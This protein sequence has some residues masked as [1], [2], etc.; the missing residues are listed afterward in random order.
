MLSIILL[1]PVSSDPPAGLRPSQVCGGTVTRRLRLGNGC[2]YRYTGELF[3]AEVVGTT[4]SAHA[5]GPDNPTKHTHTQ[6]LP[7]C[8][9]HTPAIAVKEATGGGRSLKQQ[10]LAFCQAQ[11]GPDMV[12]VTLHNGS[13]RH[14]HYSSVVA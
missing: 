6:S 11:R 12:V 1:L 5:L 10:K 4:H 8:L 14:N 7:L 3:G 13:Q 9:S 2:V